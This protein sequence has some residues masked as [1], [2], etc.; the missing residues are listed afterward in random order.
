MNPWQK[1]AA[2]VLRMAGSVIAVTGA[3]GPLYVAVISVLGG[4]AP[5]Y[6]ADRWVGSVVWLLGGVVLVALSRPL[7]RLLGRGLD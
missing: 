1:A 2:L 7:G 3:M 4:H 6:P 5:L